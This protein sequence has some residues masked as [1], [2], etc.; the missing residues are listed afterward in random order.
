[1][2]EK[3][4]MHVLQYFESTQTLKLGINGVG[5]TCECMPGVYEKFNQLRHYSPG[6]AL[7]YLKEHCTL[8]RD[9][10]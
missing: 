10:E 5:Y 6:R 9:E 2:S 3:L 4:E 8:E 1:M 7:K